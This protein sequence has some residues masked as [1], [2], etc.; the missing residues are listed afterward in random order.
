MLGCLEAAEPALQP[1][2]LVDC[3]ADKTPVKGETAD[4]LLHAFFNLAR[5][6]YRYA[7]EEKKDVCP[8]VFHAVMGDVADSAKRDRFLARVDRVLQARSVQITGKALGVLDDANVFCTSRTLS[9]LRPVFNE[10]TLEP[11]A[12][13]ILHQLKLTYHSGPR[14]VREEI[15]VAMDRAQLEELKRVVERALSKHQ[16]LVELAQKLE[17]PLLL[18]E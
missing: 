8:A 16:K 5:T 15:F 12:A 1:N 2:V 18:G 11:Q 6:V 14:G 10:D 17:S 13:V 7:P 3:V 9:E 4:D